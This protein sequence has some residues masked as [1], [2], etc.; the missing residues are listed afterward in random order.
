LTLWTSKEIAD[1]TGGDVKADFEVTGLSIDTRSLQ[2]GD[3][4]VALKD[5]RD[6]H[7]FIEA[8]I[9]K[10]AGG[11]LCVRSPENVKAVTVQSSEKALEDLG[12]Y[13]R[14]SRKALRIGVTGSVG[15]TSVKDLKWA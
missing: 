5:V 10:G 11:V 6:G 8:A 7:D 15:K 9:A 13:A 12:V 2:P 3:L 14:Q 1:A 4:F